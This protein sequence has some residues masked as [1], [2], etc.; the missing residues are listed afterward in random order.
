MCYINK[1]FDDLDAFIKLILIIWMERFKAISCCSSVWS[2]FFKRWELRIFRYIIFKY[3]ISK[4]CYIRWSCRSLH[5]SFN[6]PRLSS[7]PHPQSLKNVS[8]KTI[9]FVVKQFSS[10]FLI[11]HL[12]IFRPIFFFISSH[13]FEHILFYFEIIIIIFNYYLL[14]IQ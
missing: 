6:F 9:S 7:I 5:V 10:K 8:R 4:V 14:L 11:M 12:N 13:I 3:I 2:C 1:H